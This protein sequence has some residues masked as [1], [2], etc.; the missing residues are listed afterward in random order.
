MGMIK[1]LLWFKSYGSDKIGYFLLLGPLQNQKSKF[2]TS[3]PSYVS[4]AHQGLGRLNPK[5]LPESRKCKKT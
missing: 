2:L 3:C 4:C 5:F 1:T